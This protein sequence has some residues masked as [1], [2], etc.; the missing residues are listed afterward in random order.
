MTESDQMGGSWTARFSCT[1]KEADALASDIP[2]FAGLDTPPVLVTSEVDE[3]RPDEWRLDAYFEEK[4]KKADLQ[5]IVSL[6]P[7]SG[8]QMLPK[9]EHLPPADWLTISQQGLE[10]VS[11]GRFHIHTSNQ[12]PREGEGVRNYRIDPAQAFGTG[13]HETTYGCLAMLDRLRTR[14]AHFSSIADIGT[15]TGVLA[16]AAQHLW[17]PATIVA[18]DIDPKAVE[19]ACTYAREN[20]VS[21]GRG[22]GRLALIAAPGTDHRLIRKHGP[23]D[24]LIANILAGPLISLAPSFA[25]LTAKGGTLLLAGLIEEQQG[26]VAAAYRR[27]GFR[28]VEA[29]PEGRW[30][31][32]RLIKRP[33]FGFRRRE[34]GGDAGGQPPG[35]YGE[36]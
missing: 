2:A 9:P 28:L 11:V 35:S 22:K 26:A 32:L 21:M 10:P 13:H 25:A 36:W 20:G 5:R 31:T 16:F 17:P 7:Q 33:R 8:G 4:P 12:P 27:A 6:L 29:R 1:R 15:G 14:G 34:K 24:L 23:Y 3:A 30:P 18:S 19:T